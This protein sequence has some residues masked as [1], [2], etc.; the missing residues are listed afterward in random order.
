MILRLSQKLSARVKAGKTSAHP[1]N[2]NTFA[3]WSAHLFIAD[4]TQYV[5]LSNTK[6]LYSTVVYARGMTDDGRFI[7]RVLSGIREFMEFDG[8]ALVYQ[9]FIAPACGTVR[10]AAV[11]D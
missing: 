8:Q 7:D 4:R 5:L 2:D 9:R 3:D 6:S 10:F 11:L 1:L